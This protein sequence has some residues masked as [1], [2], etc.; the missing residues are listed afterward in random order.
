M[1]EQHSCS[2]DHLVGAAGQRQRNGDAERPGGLQV[3][4][5]LDLGRQLNRQFGGFFALENP[6]SVDA[7]EAV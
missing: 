2:F 6:P 5:H 7:G 3:D 4:V 1:S